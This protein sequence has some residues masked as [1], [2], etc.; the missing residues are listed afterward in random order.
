LST[1]CGSL[2]VSQLYK[3]PRPVTGIALPFT[4]TNTDF[5]MWALGVGEGQGMSEKDSSLRN[6]NSE[7]SKRM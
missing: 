1:K 6:E 5:V 2:D 4:F 7:S 3:P